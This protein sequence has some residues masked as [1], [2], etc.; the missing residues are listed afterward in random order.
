MSRLW[1]LLLLAVLVLL[2]PDVYLRFLRPAT[3]WSE[4]RGDWALI[5]GSSFGIGRAFALELAERGLN[6]VLHARTRGKLEAV[7]QEIKSLYPSTQVRIVVQDAVEAPN[8]DTMPALIADLNITVLINNIGG[9]QVGNEDAFKK[10]HEL[11]WEY[12]D[13][14]E[15]FNWGAARGW[16]LLTLPKMVAAKRGRIIFCSSGAYLHG[17]QMS[18]Y[19]ASKGAMHSLTYLIN[20]EYYLLGIRAEAIV[21]G[22][23]S[24][25]AV[26]MIEPD[27][28]GYTV[29][30]EHLATKALDQFGWKEVYAPSLGHALYVNTLGYYLPL[31]VR[32]KSVAE[33]TEA[34]EADLRRGS[35]I[36]KQIHDS[37]A[38]QQA[39]EKTDL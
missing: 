16:T 28:L 34:M 6:I 39:K 30:A 14:V 18:M 5:T 15:R 31:S 25:P 11:P 4:Y 1:W 19:G 7:A 27:W 17:Y 32:A 3:D 26:G 37:A 8:W 35:A 10:M 33:S 9:G 13:K 24:T 22:L 12:H 38:K 20:N 21:I 23:V 29:T 36:V 2:G